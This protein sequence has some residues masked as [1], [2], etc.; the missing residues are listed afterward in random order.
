MDERLKKA[1]DFSNY[2]ITLDNQ[3]RILKEKYQEDLLYYYGG[4]TFIST[5]ELITF[6]YS[7]I[8][9]GQEDTVIVDSNDIPINVN[10]QEFVQGVS[11]TY[12][13]ASNKYYVEY[14]KL[15]T[16][17]SVEGMFDTWAKVLY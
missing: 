13:R 7:M 10:L 4:G 6:C 16:N 17:R 5:K 15:K 3:K 14:D 11:D 2:M 12:F 9:A 1:L 8:S